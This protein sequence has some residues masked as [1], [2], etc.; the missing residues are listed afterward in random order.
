[1]R[2]ESVE[3]NLAERAG[4]KFFLMGWNARLAVTGWR[5]ADALIDLAIPLFETEKSV[6]WRGI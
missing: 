6:K 1:V 5:R 3:A 4:A 2:P